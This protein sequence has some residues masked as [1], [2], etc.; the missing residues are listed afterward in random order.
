MYRSS[1]RNSRRD[2]LEGISSMGSTPTKFVWLGHLRVNSNNR[3]LFAGLGGSRRRLAE[4]PVLK[5]SD[6][7]K[8]MRANGL[9]LR[10]SSLRFLQVYEVQRRIA[11]SD[12]RR[13]SG[14]GSFAILGSIRRV[15][16]PFGNGLSYFLLMLKR[17]G[18]ERGPAQNILFWINETAASVQAVGRRW[19]IKRH[20]TKRL[21]SRSIANDF[22]HKAVR[23]LDT[24]RY[25]RLPYSLRQFGLWSW[26]PPWRFGLSCVF[27]IA[28][29]NERVVCFLARALSLATYSIGAC[30][31]RP[32]RRRYG[33]SE[34][35][36][37][38]RGRRLWHV[39]I[40]DLNPR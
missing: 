6:L 4:F 11:S 18:R 15:I 17:G 26:S 24:G 35:V 13:R 23:R 28:G 29:H 20:E 27:F 32:L 30:R 8:Y 1:W 3:L 5:F 36:L 12:L 10:V 9:P 40:E 34:K 19:R 22:L 39:V 31:W 2:K 7:S 33:I 21:S 14:R 25:R 37:Y 16:L 38:S